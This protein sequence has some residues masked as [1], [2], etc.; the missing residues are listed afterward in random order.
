MI[1]GHGI[2]W[3][4]TVAIFEFF[5]IGVYCIFLNWKFHH[6]LLFYTC[7]KCNVVLLRDCSCREMEDGWHLIQHACI[8]CRILDVVYI[9]GNCSKVLLCSF[10]LAISQGVLKLAMFLSLL[11]MEANSCSCLSLSPIP[12][13]LGHPISW[14]RLSRV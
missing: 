13:L 10:L 7:Q 2:V 5:L 14:P 4:T 11:S 8:C 1:M 9:L 6:N 3:S 12:F